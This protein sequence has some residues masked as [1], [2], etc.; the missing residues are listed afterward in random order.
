MWR[1][2]WPCPGAGLREG[3]AVANS[4]AE[5]MDVWVKCLPAHMATSQVDAKPT[6]AG[7]LFLLQV[8]V[9]I[10]GAQRHAVWCDIPMQTAARTLRIGKPVSPS[11]YP[12]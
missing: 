6:S 12:A 3:A 4:R 5:L 1:L 7:S 11:C 8:R 9:K 2:R 10:H